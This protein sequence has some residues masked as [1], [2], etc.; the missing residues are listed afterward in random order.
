MKKVAPVVMVAASLAA[1]EPA[2]QPPPPTPAGTIAIAAD[3]PLEGAFVSYAQEEVQGARFAVE[4]HPT[5]GRFRL[6]FKTFD[7]SLAGY[8]NTTKGVQNVRKIAADPEVLGMVGPFNS[9]VAAAQ[10]PVANADDLAILSPSTT[11]DCLTLNVPGC[12]PPA[13]PSGINNFFRIAARDSDQG[14]AMADFTVNELHRPRVAVLSDGFPY[15]EGLAD[16]FVKE[17]T[18][19]GGT[20]VLREKFNASTYDFSEV[21]NRVKAGGGQAIYVGGVTGTGACRIRTKM[22]DL[23]PDAYFLGADGV[24][25][26]DCTKDA[27][28]GANERMIATSPEPGPMG[29]PRSQKVVDDYTRTHRPL[30]AYTFAAYDCAEILINAIGRAIDA[31]GGKLPSRL[32][33]IQA[34]AS[35]HF[36]GV[37][38]TWSFDSRGDPTVPGVSLYRVHTGAWA[39]WQAV[40]LSK[41]SP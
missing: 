4:R 18:A 5:I 11:S 10:I 16:S 6:V 17:L 22:P 41:Q 30:G 8:P 25:D 38:G 34:L 1:C 35:I 12:Q 23:L 36:A 37:T 2:S 15:G 7:D 14:R 28:S 32:Q 24:I 9:F 31:N 19:V 13:R 39:F 3:F 33:V 20:V 21:L 40:S 29:N 26:R 27:G